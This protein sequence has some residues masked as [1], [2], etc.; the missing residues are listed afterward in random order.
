MMDA[1]SNMKYNPATSRE[2][3]YNTTPKNESRQYPDSLNVTPIRNPVLANHPMKDEGKMG[4]RATA[5]KACRIHQ[6]EIAC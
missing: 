6:I 5:T 3:Q 1:D 4:N 2:M